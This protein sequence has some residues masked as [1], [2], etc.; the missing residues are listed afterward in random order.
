MLMLALA[1]W[2]GAQEGSPA[3]TYEELERAL[4]TGSFD[5]SFGPD[6]RLKSCAVTKSTGDKDLD[7]IYCPVVRKCAAAQP[8]GSARFNCMDDE[9]RAAMRDI[10]SRRV[11]EHQR[12]IGASNV[13]N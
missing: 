9:T 1:G 6:G 12:R 3:T 2:V 8:K 7:Q 11:A 13:T 10:A 5:H 4:G